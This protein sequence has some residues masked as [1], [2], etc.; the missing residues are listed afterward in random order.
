MNSV[1]KSPE[2]W[3]KYTRYNI[4]IFQNKKQNLNISEIKEM[5]KQATSKDGE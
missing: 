3:R 2:K 1:L 4:M 5:K